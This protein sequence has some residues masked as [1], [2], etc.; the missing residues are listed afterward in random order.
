MSNLILAFITGILTKLVDN[1]EDEGSKINETLKIIFAAT[2]GIMIAYLITVI[3]LP[4]FWFGI[5]IGLIL[6]GKIDSQSH[7]I[8]ISTLLATLALLGFPEMNASIVVIVALICH[9]EEWINTEIVD[10]N[11]VKGFLKKLLKI[12]PILEITAIILSVI[13]SNFTIFL[14]LFSFDLGYLLVEPIILK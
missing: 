5:I 2:Y 13:Y 7:Y 12:R 10:K 11:K 1:A 3:P 6:S 8:G 4:S 14:L 9:L